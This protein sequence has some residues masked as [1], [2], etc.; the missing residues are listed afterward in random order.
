MGALVL[1]TSIGIGF[2]SLRISSSAMESSIIA[3]IGDMNESNAELLS[4][5][6]NRQL[7]VL[8]E[9]A[10]RA[11]T[12]TMDEELIRP[13]LMPDVSRINA[14]EMA[15]LHP[16]GISRDILAGTSF[17]ISHR[18]YFKRAMTG[19]KCVEL[20]ISRLSGNLEVVFAVPVMRNDEPGAQAIGVLISRK[21]GSQTLSDIVVN[22][23][24]SMPS[25]YSYLMDMQGTVIAHLDAEMVR[26]QFNPI[27]ESEKNPSFKPMADMTEKALAEKTGISRY[28]FDGKS[29]IGYYTE[30]PGFPWLLFNIIEK[31]DIDSQL[32]NMRN[33]ILLFGF[34]F[35]A[36]GFAIAF[37]IG[38]SI[39]KPIIRVA[40]TLED[41]AQG[42]GDLTHSITINSKDEIGDLA[43]FF[44][45]TIKKIRDLVGIMIY[46]VNALTNTSF[47]LT[48]N[49]QK[50]SHAVDEISANFE[51]MKGLEDIQ[52]KEAEKAN[53]AVE[54][55]I[56]N[57]DNLSQLVDEQADSVNTSSSA[58][59]QMTAN[60]Q[61]VTKTLVENSK[62]VAALG[63]ASENGKTGL[64][65]VAQEIQEIARDS[66]GLLE[67]NSV[68][69]NIASQ[70][71]LLSMNA[72]IEAAHA[73]EAGR[74]FAVVA[75][76]IR[77]LAES[78]GQQSKT[79]AAML[80]KIKTSIDSITRSS[81]DVLSRFDAIDSGVKTVTEHEQNIRNAMEEQ[82]AGGKQILESVGRLKDIT[83]SVKNGAG[84]MS[85]SGGELI[86]KINE[87]IGISG[88]VVQGMNSILSG[89]VNE[90]KAAVKHVDEMS[91]ENHKNF[92][93]LKQ[94][95]GKFKISGIDEKKTVLVVDDDEVHL[96]LTKTML[97]S[98]YNI[99]T[100]KSGQEAIT[101]FYRGLVPGA[102]LLDLIMPGMDGWDTYERIKAIGNLH[103]VP[104]AFFTASN[105]PK[106]R[107]KAEGMGAVDYI[108]KPAEKDDLIERLRRIVKK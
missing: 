97:E 10:N 81:N 60:I 64:S 3:G 70:T 79:T 107:K 65:T 19:E 30:V 69:E 54:G 93:E 11:R 68:M 15:L 38:R 76:E 29:F 47:E 41:I 53:K 42:E 22:L 7:D 86:K 80:K 59:E 105:D 57:I 66:E 77:K 44:N 58:I 48:S 36:G 75:D 92:T 25:A 45:L 26:N 14:I 17:D 5:T 28:T 89:A 32:V 108:L 106:D 16:T 2:I 31:T 62:N 13:S 46:K 67:I 100:V 94:E 82:E 96:I 85:L 98:D 34:L 63:E 88:Q 102:I 87:F 43:H 18:D 61:S 99:I 55:I 73:G 23:K 104:I 91:V 84:S 72:A 40:N 103:E 95:T 71:N 6:I 39:T 1:I 20:V 50:T 33:I 21:D 27:K 9:I 49:M 24:S 52:E 8:W 74:G 51:G 12:R 90:I 56:T 78:S 35:I 101:L 83:L 37:F 4:S